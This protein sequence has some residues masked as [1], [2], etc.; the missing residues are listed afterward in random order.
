MSLTVFGIL[1]FVL[2]L[3][4]VPVAFS[5]LGPSLIYL[6]SNGQSVGLASRLVAMGVNSFALLAVPLFILLGVIA[7][8][9]GI[10]D[11][12]FD[13]AMESLGR[14]RGSLGYVN[15]LVSLGFSW[16]SGSALAD[17]A[18]LGKVQ[19]PAMMKRGYP[20][21]F[22][23]GVTAGSALI[24]PVMPPSIPAVIFASVAAVSTGALFAA[25]V[26][27]AFLMA[28]GM[29]VTVWVW[30]RKH[31]E[32]KGEPFNLRRWWRATVRVSGPAVAPIIILGGILGGVFTP[33]EAAGVGALYVLLLGFIYGTI[34]L[35]DIPSILKE[36][37]T[38][39]ASITLI[40]GSSAVLGWILAKEQV[41]QAVARLL[42][43]VTD[44][45]IVLLL[46][47]NLLLIVL[48]MFI[49]PTS[50]LV[51]SV[52]ILLPIA[53]QFGVEPIHFGVIVIINLMI[54][55]LTPPLGGV[56]FVL[57]TVTKTPIEEAFKGVLPF[58]I[59]LF[60]VLLIVTFVP[61]I[62]LALPQALGFL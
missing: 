4:R 13:A 56:L 29:L 11:R 25:A 55:L 50:A 34:R 40:L 3:A 14:L 33:T 20:K 30:A 32:L 9:S 41:P 2:L 19:V 17:A 46:L 61:M 58:L 54:G 62:A 44:N 18:G 49:E 57:S 39:T 59:P 42:L 35:R 47:I 37:T 12:I 43:S 7:N 6:I 15:V 31:P 21:R 36:A 28:L 16:M 27:P 23:V 53:V 26:L 24:S 48:G 5:I 60:S 45:P 1:I 51:I 52:P 10:A 8:R 22:S 38:T